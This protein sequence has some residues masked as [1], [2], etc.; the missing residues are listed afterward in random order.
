[1][2]ENV[3][4]Q[5]GKDYWLK[6]RRRTGTVKARCVRTT[7]DWTTVEILSGTWTGLGEGVV[8]RVGDFAYVRTDF[9]TIM[10]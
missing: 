9:L 4:L 10:P 7:G 3:G 1:M 8:D 5:P 6:H 2:A